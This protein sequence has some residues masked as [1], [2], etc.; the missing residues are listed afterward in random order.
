MIKK[1]YKSLSNCMA[2]TCPSILTA[3]FIVVAFKLSGHDL[4]VGLAF[5]WIS[6]FFPSTPS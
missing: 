2:A 5:L 3:L 1:S 4:V 6:F